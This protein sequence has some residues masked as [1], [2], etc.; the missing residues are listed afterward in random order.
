MV[1]RSRAY[2]PTREAIRPDVADV[3]LADRI[4]AP[5]YAAPLLR[6][7]TAATALRETRAAD[8]AVLT[9]LAVGEP[10]ELLDVTGETGWGIAPQHGLVGYIDANAIG[11]VA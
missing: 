1:G 2:D 6:R 3:R 8:S 10:F 9:M 11:P 5:H 7:V 4:F